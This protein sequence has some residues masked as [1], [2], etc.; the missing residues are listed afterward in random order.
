MGSWF[1][2]GLLFSFFNDLPPVKVG[3]GKAGIPREDAGPSCHTASA[4]RLCYKKG[5]LRVC[6]CLEN[7]MDLGAGTILSMTIIAWAFLPVN[8]IA[9][10]VCA[11]CAPI[12]CHLGNLY[13]KLWEYMLKYSCKNDIINIKKLILGGEIYVG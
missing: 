12:W 4:W 13:G 9:V 1:P 8:R 6:R 5:H 7:G 3:M 2:V 10:P 11:I